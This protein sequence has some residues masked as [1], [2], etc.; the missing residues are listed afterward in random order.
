MSPSTARI[1]RNAAEVEADAVRGAASGVNECRD[2]AGRPSAAGP[3]PGSARAAGP[4]PRSGRRTTSTGS[5]RHVAGPVARALDSSRRATRGRPRVGCGA[6][7]ACHAEGALRR[8]RRGSGRTAG[9]PRRG[10]RAGPTP[11][12]SCAGR[13]GRRSG[14]R[15]RACGSG[16]SSRRSWRCPA[17]PGLL[18]LL[19]ARGAVP[20]SA[21]EV[22][23]RH[24]RGLPDHGSTRRSPTSPPTSGCGCSHPHGRLCRAPGPDRGRR[25]ASARQPPRRSGWPSTWTPRS[26]HAGP[27]ES[28]SVS[29]GRRS[30]LGRAGGGAGPRDRRAAHGLH[31]DGLMSLRGTDRRCRGPATGARRCRGAAIRAMQARF[32]RPSWRHGGQRSWRVRGVADL[33][34]VNGGGT[35]QPRGDERRGSRHRGRRRERSLRPA[36]VRPLLRRSGR[37]RPRSVRPARRPSACAGLGHAVRRRLPGIGTGRSRTDCRRSTCPGLALTGTEGAGE[38]QTPVQGAAADRPA[39]RRARVAASREGRRAGR[40]V[41]RVP[42]RRGGARGR[43][44]SHLPRRGPELRMTPDDG[45]SAQPPTNPA[46]CA[47][48]AVALGHSG[49][50]SEGRPLRQ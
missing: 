24:R 47:S 13:T 15:P 34:F 31:L 19:A 29:A 8:R 16:R 39:D 44:G 17:T 4:S 48:G 11:R 25:R 22:L 27:P 32:R 49:Q 7:R 50:V 5:P 28:T 33:R 23:G 36:P 21:P 10:G 9:H 6:W 18:G 41:H 35:G 1:P 38:V 43:Y 3:R 40:A 2:P 46:G 42:P 26:D 20:V 37:S 30:A 12:T 14:W 45:G